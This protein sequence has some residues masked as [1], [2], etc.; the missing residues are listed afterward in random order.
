MSDLQKFLSRKDIVTLIVTV[1][2]GL[3][4][5]LGGAEAVGVKEQGTELVT[6]A[7][8]L[9]AAA[10]VEGSYS[11]VKYYRSVGEWFGSR[12]NQ[13]LIGMIL[14]ALVN[15]GLKASGRAEIPP[16]ILDNLLSYVAPAIIV[17]VA[18]V[19]ANVKA[20]QFNVEPLDR[21][22]PDYTAPLRGE[23]NMLRTR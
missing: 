15:A 2:V 14:L 11:Q 3:F 5:A 16:V 9:M 21:H 22:P 6:V 4:V 20:R 10:Y 8:T 19:D 12:K 18:A 7:L 1:A 17:F 23:P 13:V